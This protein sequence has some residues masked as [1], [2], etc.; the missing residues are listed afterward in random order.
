MPLPTGCDV[1]AQGHKLLAYQVPCGLPRIC[2]VEVFSA[3]NKLSVLLR[4]SSK[5]RVAGL[6][7]D[8]GS[9]RCLRSSAYAAVFASTQDTTACAGRL[10][11]G[12]ITSAAFISK[13]GRWRSSAVRRF[14]RNVV[15][16]PDALTLTRQIR[17]K[18]CFFYGSLD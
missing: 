9:V 3:E 16:A 7:G 5:R 4:L 8:S 11:Y 13:S 12:P 14:G 6:P 18:R 17:P 1:G 15:L 2:P 10:R